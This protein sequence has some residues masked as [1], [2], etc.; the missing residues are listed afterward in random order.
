MSTR[1]ET[2]KDYFANGYNCAQSV[3]LTFKDSHKIDT[4]TA[5]R[6]VNCLGGGISK[7]GN[8]C[9]ALSS[10]CLAMSAK[11]GKKD[12]SEPER[13]AQTYENTQAIIDGFKTEFGSTAC[14]DLLGYDLAD[15]EQFQAAVD[16]NAFQNICQKYVQ[17]AA[18]LA[19]RYID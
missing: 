12:P 4:E 2:A 11:C 7:T 3:F 15:P 17:C 8:I 16:A 1:K 14:P 5:G 6:L 18:E 19:S 13:Q 10:A 9:G